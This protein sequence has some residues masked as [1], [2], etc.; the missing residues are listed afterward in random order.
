ME[1]AAEG[2]EGVAILFIGKTG[3]YRANIYTRLM[4]SWPT[5][6]SAERAV[7]GTRAKARA[8]ARARSWPVVTF[9]SFYM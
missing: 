8:R 3:R 5:I 6:I 9:K 1:G 4:P 7:A 2:E